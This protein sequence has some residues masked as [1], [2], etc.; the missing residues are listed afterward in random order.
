MANFRNYMR[1]FLVVFISIFCCTISAQNLRFNVAQP[2]L[3]LHSYSKQQTDAFAFLN[4]QAALTN[5]TKTQIG[6]FAENRFGLKELALYN[7][8]GAFATNLGNIGVQVQRGGGTNF[9]ENKLGLAYGRK[10]SDKIA[11]GA[12]FNYYG[13]NVPGVQKSNTVFFELGI[14]AHASEKLHV[15][16]QVQNPVGGNLKNTT[17]KVASLYS[18]GIGY[19]ASNE[20]FIGANLS[21][22]ENTDLQANIGFNY[23]FYKKFFAK[24]GVLTNQGFLYAGAGVA[25]NGVRFDISAS[26][27]PQLGFSP[28]ISI[29]TQFK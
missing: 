12:Q 5:I 6:V 23:N 19:D 26:H 16:F 10:L 24:A 20:F 18:I 29:L 3:A 9:N 13:Y 17:E 7:I 8:V 15:G 25:F 22:E 2:Y 14:L 28:A 4:N 1:S 21:K 11:V 27:H